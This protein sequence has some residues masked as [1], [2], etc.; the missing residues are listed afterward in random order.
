VSHF[1]VTTALAIAT[2]S[3]P[4]T[5]LVGILVISFGGVLLVVA[6][7][8]LLIADRIE[9]QQP[10]EHV[11]AVTLAV[12][13]MVMVFFTNPFWIGALYIVVATSVLGWWP[14]RLIQRFSK[15]NRSDRQRQQQLDALQAEG[16]ALKGELDEAAK[17]AQAAIE[18]VGAEGIDQAGAEAL[19]QLLSLTHRSY[20][21]V[22]KHDAMAEQLRNDV[23]HVAR[24]RQRT[25][26]AFPIL[27]AVL[28]L[29]FVLTNLST[30]TPWLP[31]E[32]FTMARGQ[33]VVGYQLGRDGSQAVVLRDFDRLVIIDSVV[34]AT[35][36]STEH[37]PPTILRSPLELIYSALRQPRYRRCSRRL[38]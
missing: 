31:A 3:N 16:A 26:I 18:G 9:E 38:P 24:V 17:R 19:Q 6:F 4:A 32:S 35:I 30:D 29:L 13:T 28:L 27:W 22:Q 11:V 1:D 15:W 2:Q 20:G 25:L 36:C 5:V 14:G 33:R 21:M 12:I 10:S 37:R 23:H 7:L 34:S 8:V